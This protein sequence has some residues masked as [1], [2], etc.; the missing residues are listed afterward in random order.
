M[1]LGGFN[2]QVTQATV[3]A[4][5]DA[6]IEAPVEAVRLAYKDY[7]DKQV[8]GHDYRF[9]P[10]APDF[11]ARV[12]MRQA[13]LERQER[14]ALPPA[15]K[16]MTR[17]PD[18]SLSVPVGIPFDWDG[19][20][21]PDGSTTN[22]GH[23]NIQLGGLTRREAEIVERMGGMTPTGKNFARLSLAEKRAEI[24]RYLPAPVAA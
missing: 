8:P 23:G 22:C 10:T 17:L 5:V 12:R 24:A 15:P 4:Y 2:S 16:G 20:V 18:G 14:P 11:G 1:L 19:A 6:V 7:R 3:S 13:I 21:L 9:A